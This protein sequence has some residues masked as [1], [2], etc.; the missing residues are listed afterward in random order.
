M[1]HSQQINRFEWLKA[2]MQSRDEEIT[3]NAKNVATALAIQFTCNETGKLNPK[4]TT[5]E[6]Y[7]GLS[8]ATVK[9][10]IRALVDAGWLHRTEGRGA[11]NSTEYSLTS[12]GKIVPFRQPKRVQECPLKKGSEVSLQDEKKGSVVSPKGVSTEPSYIEQS[13]EQYTAP[14]NRYRD[15]RF[16]G[17]GFPGL[18]VV[19]EKTHWVD[20][21][22]WG[23]WL[24]K[25]GLPPLFSY[26]LKKVS[27][28]GKTFWRLPWKTP[29]DTDRKHD[30][31]VEFFSALLPEQE[32]RYAAE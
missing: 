5:L 13:S 15:H 18:T 24:G 4:V 17:N 26:P 11:G 25:N 27:D 31:A 29:P 20:L 19:D 28:K 23:Q 32:V 7:L 10:A 1:T 2:V 30:E 16:E 21:A 22:A 8:K 12:P 9:R 6:E 14:L 3:A